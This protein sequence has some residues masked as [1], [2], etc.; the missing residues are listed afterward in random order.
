MLLLYDSGTVTNLIDGFIKFM[1]QESIVFIS[2]LECISD[3][4]PE[5]NVNISVE[6]IYSASSQ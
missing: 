6:T 4:F 1:N 5:I 3:A 2:I